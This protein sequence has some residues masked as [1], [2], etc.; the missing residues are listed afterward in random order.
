MFLPQIALVAEPA[1]EGET[2]LWGTALDWAIMLT[3]G[4]SALIL[5]CIL[6][7]LVAYRGRQ[8]EGS[9]LWLHLLALG[10]FPLFLMVVSNFAVLEYAKEVQF[11]GTCHV[12]MKPY[13]DDLNNPKSESLAALHYQH[14]A[15]PGSECYTCHANYG[16]H[17]TFQAKLAGL[18]DVY[19]YVTGTYHLP[20]RLT[21]PFQN[22]LCLKCHNGAKRFMAEQNH[23]ED[24]GVARAFRT[25]E[26]QCVECHSPTHDISKPTA[27]ARPARSG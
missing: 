15:A 22:T 27:S 2:L 14:R 4:L 16:L 24:G 19:K 6:V 13:I 7:S 20:I 12:T 17:G 10:I 25:G 9:A 5:G 11:C 21:K 18:R 8:A 26:T 1:V 3:S 23:L